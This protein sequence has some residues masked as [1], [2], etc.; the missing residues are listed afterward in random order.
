LPYHGF[1]RLLLA[2]L[3]TLLCGRLLPAA[4]LARACD[5]G[6]RFAAIT[7]LCC[8]TTKDPAPACCELMERD[9]DEPAAPHC[10]GCACE[11]G[12]A[13][14]MTPPQGL[15]LPRTADAQ[16]MLLPAPALLPGVRGVWRVCGAGAGVAPTGP[17]GR[18]E[19]CVW[20]L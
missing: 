10:P 3:V 12:E 11:A 5:G 7:C 8:E 2:I 6:A 17:P 9:E 1:V 16:P 14:Q 13:P 20:V 4:G 15:A 18:A 19:L